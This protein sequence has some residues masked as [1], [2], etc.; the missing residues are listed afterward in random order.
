ML[1]IPNELMF[2]VPADHAEAIAMERGYYLH[3]RHSGRDAVRLTGK[4]RDNMDSPMNACACACACVCVGV[5][6]GVGAEWRGEWAWL[7][8]DLVR[9][10]R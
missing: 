10:S 4:V 9:A 6:M 8:F 1:E 7:K 5:N 3:A 2:Q